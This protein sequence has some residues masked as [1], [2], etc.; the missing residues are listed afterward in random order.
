MLQIARGILRGCAFGTP[1]IGNGQPRVDASGALPI[2]G[3][4]CGI[5]WPGV[6]PIVNRHVPK[7][8]DAVF[9][10]LMPTARTQARTFK[11]STSGKRASVIT[12][13]AKSATTIMLITLC[14]YRAE[15]VT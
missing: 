7:S 10:N 11:H 3:K 15:E 13:N 1:P 12:A 4:R 5:T 14:P 2:L 8:H 9:A 6:L